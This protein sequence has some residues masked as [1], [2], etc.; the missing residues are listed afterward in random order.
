MHRIFSFVLIVS[1]AAIVGCPKKTSPDRETPRRDDKPV[2]SQPALTSDMD[3]AHVET[4]QRLINSGLAYLLSEQ[5][6]DGGWRIGPGARPAATGIVLKVLVQHPS[7]DT[8]HPA[9]KRGF[10]VLLSYQRP[11][12]GI[13][14]PKEGLENY[15]T[16]IALMAI[17][18]SGDPRFNEAKRRA[19]G[20]LR[21]LIIRPGSK[22]PRGAEI[23][24]DHPMR[25]GVSY[26][27]HGRPDLSNVGMWVQAMHEAGIKGDD[28][29]MQEVLTFVTRTQNSTEKNASAWAVAGPNDGGFVY[30]PALR[31]NLKMGESKAGAAV[32]GGRGLRSYGSMTYMGFKSMLHANVDRADPR[33]RAAF[34]WIRRHWRLDSNPNMPQEKSLQGLYYYYQ[35]YAKALRAWG[36]PVI[37]DFKGKEHNWR[38][39]LVNTL[40]KRVGDDG[41][42]VNSADRWYE[43][44]KVLVTGYAVLALQEAMKK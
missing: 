35:V 8:S 34:D 11:D 27:K 24:A 31:D 29:D 20:Y 12:G 5:E 9:V 43:G 26:G 6:A 14:D 19:I 3:A 44:S 7:Y 17:S 30:A 32:P 15:T 16:S 38:E 37:R 36:E 18:A 22:G 23:G 2:A 1:L 13:Y 42:W 39:E 28:P 4:A 10:D 41:S 21:G 40:A 25:G 33:V